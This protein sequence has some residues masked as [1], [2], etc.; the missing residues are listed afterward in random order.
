M[1]FKEIYDRI[2]PLWGDRIDFSDGYIIQPERKYKNL[3]SVTDSE[4]YFYSPK[5]SNLWNS[6]EENIEEKDTYGELMVW[7]IYQVFHKYAR[8]RFE[9]DIF[10]FSPEEIENK[11]IEEHYFK[12]LNEEGWEDELLQYQ[13][14]VE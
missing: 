4:D 3:R 5:L 1:T 12:N 14:G 9:Q 6:I 8:E 11:I 2:I 10:S 13:R 7:T